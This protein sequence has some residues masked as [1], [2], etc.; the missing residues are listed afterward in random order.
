V[1]IVSDNA[2]RLERAATALSAVSPAVS[3]IQCDVG[4][5]ESVQAM[6]QTMLARFGPP[7]ILINNAGFATYRTYEATPIE[8]IERLVSVNFLGSLRC[9]SAFLPAM[10][11]AKRGTIV[12]VASIAG[13][14]PLTPHGTYSAAK[15][16]LIAWAQ[17]LRAEVARFGIRVLVICPGRV[18][19]PFFH[20]ET[21]QARRRKGFETRPN[22]TPAD[23]SRATFGAIESGRFMTYVPAY[24]GPLQWAINAFPWLLKPPIEWVIRRRVEDLYD[25]TSLPHPELSTR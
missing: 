4:Y 13:R 9:T 1:V 8:E 20:H 6:A 15:F 23:V 22:L 3:S 12:N 17:T 5:S 19:T 16:A 18:D 2:E 14:V 11:A 25:E 7:D 10:I 24:L 21:F